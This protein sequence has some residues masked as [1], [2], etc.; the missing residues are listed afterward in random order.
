[1]EVAES[2]VIG[3]VYKYGINIWHIDTAL[4][5][6][7]CQKYVVLVVDEVYYGLFQLSRWHL[8]VCYCYSCFG[9]YFFQFFLEQ[10]DVLYLVVDEKY[11]PVALHLESYC[12]ADSLFVEFDK[13]GN[14]WISIGWRSVYYR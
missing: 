3:I 8:P 9:D 2:E 7:R 4:D 13:L 6:G 5:Y 11:L 14:D 1:M 10:I 12:L